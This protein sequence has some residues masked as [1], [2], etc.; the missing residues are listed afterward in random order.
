MDTALNEQDIQ[1]LEYFFPYHYISEFR[2]GFSQTFN[3]TWGLYHASTVE[4]LMEQL[5]RFEFRSIADIGCGDG[6]FTRELAIEFPG[7]KVI[8][9][10]YSKKAIS[11]AKALNP[12]IP[13]MQVDIIR[14]TINET[15]DLIT[16]IEVLEHIPLDQVGDFIQSVADLLNPGGRLIMT[17][18]HLNKPLEDKHFQHFTLKS[19]EKAT[20][21]VFKIDK[22]VFFERST[23]QSK[24]LNKVLTNQLFILNQRQLKN[25]IYWIYKTWLFSASEKNCSRMYLELS[26]ATSENLQ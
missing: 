8:G 23:I 18:P 6:R 12:L 24:V 9:I 3:W 17:V 19:L 15:F 2:N 11:M 13:F 20:S 4:F 1:E 10:D 25:F 16:L 26:K 7:K 21:F 22:A 14:S 5:R